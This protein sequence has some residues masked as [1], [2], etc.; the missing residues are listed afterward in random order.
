MNDD[1][2]AWFICLCVHYK[3][4]CGVMLCILM[5]AYMGA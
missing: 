5:N 1:A 4:S 2:C 3:Q